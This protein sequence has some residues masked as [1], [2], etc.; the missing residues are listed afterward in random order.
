L[1]LTFKASDLYNRILFIGFSASDYLSLD[2]LLNDKEKE[3]RY[4]ARTFAQEYVAPIV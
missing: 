3:A 1:N 4:L 2:T